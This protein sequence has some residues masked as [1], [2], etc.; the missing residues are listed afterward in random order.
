MGVGWRMGWLTLFLLGGLAMSA[1]VLLGLRRP[2]WSLAGAALMLGATGYAL[3]GRPTLPGQPARP[4]ASATPIDP[5]LIDLRDRMLGRPQFSSDGA[6]LVAADAMTRI[7][8]PRAAV[9][10][11]LGGIKHV[12]RSLMLWVGLGEALE[13]HDGGRLSPPALF[14]FQQAR[15]IAPDHPAPY[16]FLGLAYV[17][18]GDFAAARPLWARALALS[19]VQASYHDDIA[20]RLALLDRLQAE[21]GRQGAR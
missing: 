19:P 7:G 12:P 17:R 1:L 13:R 2:L 6:Y 18:A 11:I 8:E 16:F 5:A 21:M 20:L 9:Q 14:A 15:R 10:A 4:E 3:Q